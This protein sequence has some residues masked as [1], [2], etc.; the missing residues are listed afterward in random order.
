MAVDDHG[1]SVT[2]FPY[3][4]DCVQNGKRRVL[5]QADLNSKHLPA[6]RPALRDEGKDFD[7]RVSD[8]LNSKSLV[9]SGHAGLRFPFCKTIMADAFPETPILIGTRTEDQRGGFRYI[10]SIFLFLNLFLDMEGNDLPQKEIM[11]P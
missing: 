3:E 1:E 8:F 4:Q 7:I 2:L 11:A 5:G 6:H 10:D 9:A